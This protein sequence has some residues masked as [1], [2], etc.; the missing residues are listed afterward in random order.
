MTSFVTV[1][2]SSD[3][4]N[5]YSNN[6]GMNSI[7]NMNNHFSNIDLDQQ[8]TSSNEHYSPYL[9]LNDAV[10]CQTDTLLT[11]DAMPNIL[12]HNPPFSSQEQRRSSQ[13]KCLNFFDYVFLS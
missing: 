4:E 10:T 3:Q 12:S 11:A 1:F 8:P 7:N 2:G 9:S 5:H 13:I 6:T